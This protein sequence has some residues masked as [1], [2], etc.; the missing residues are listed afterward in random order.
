MR[1]YLISILLVSAVASPA[2][3]AQ[4]RDSGR[5]A[6]WGERD[7][8]RSDRTQSRDERQQFREQFRA[9]RPA[10]A[11][12]SQENRSDGSRQRAGGVSRWTRDTVQQAGEASRWTRDPMQR[13]GETARWTRDRSNVGQDAG[14]SAQ[15]QQRWSG[16][17]GSWNRAGNRTQPQAQNRSRWANGWNRDWRSNSRYD[18][19][20]YRDNHRST[21]RLGVYVDPFGFGYRPFSAGYHLGPAYYGQR[22]WID[23]GLYSLPYP[24]PGTQWVRYWD[25]AV[26]VDVYSGEIVDVINNFFW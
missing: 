10:A 15:A 7:Q 8:S 3:A 13:T 1:K 25:D 24:P 2:L 17:G 21:F 22:Y 6:A 5:R 18:W 16:Q 12:Q 11:D 23:P 14:Q 4:D 26:L 19:R 20:R 9:E